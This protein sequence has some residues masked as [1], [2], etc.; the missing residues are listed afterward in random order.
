MLLNAVAT[1]AAV[2][3]VYLPFS[4]IDVVFFVFACVPA[5]PV[6]LLTS[7]PLIAPPQPEFMTSARIQLFNNN[8]II[9]VSEENF[10]FHSRFLSLSTTVKT[11]AHTHCIV[12]FNKYQY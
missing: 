1:A 4:C 2:C 11:R 10:A 7:W 8:I 3:F 9:N 5:F 6:P 12:L